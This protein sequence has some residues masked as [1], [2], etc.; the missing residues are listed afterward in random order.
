[1]NSYDAVSKK[2]GKNKKI[3]LPSLDFEKLEMIVNALEPFFYY[4]KQLSSRKSSIAEILPIFYSVKS[5]F[6]NDL[7]SESNAKELIE[8]TIAEKLIFRMQEMEKNL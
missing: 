5:M 2:T 6:S 7:S 1:M 8:Q 4:T 3:K